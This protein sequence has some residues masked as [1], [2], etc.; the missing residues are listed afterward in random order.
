ME[1]WIGVAVVAVVVALALVALLVA[2]RLRRPRP[3]PYELRRF[4]TPAER[5]FFRVL[6][7]AVGDEYALFAKV[8]V[9]D[10]LKVRQ[11]EKDFAVHFNRISAKHVDFLLCDPSDVSPVLAIEL[12]DATHER[13]D[14]RRR[15][16]FLDEAF[17]SAGLPLARFRAGTAYDPAQ[18]ADE[19]AEAIAT[20]DAAAVAAER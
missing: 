11:G 12:D 16:A 13:A 4:L 5:A 7:D 17:A 3:G 14:R 6:R 1:T 10:I 20:G 18:L 2:M 9:A 19:I 15:D 8:R